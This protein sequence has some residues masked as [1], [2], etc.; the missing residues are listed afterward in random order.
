M[1]R[2][3]GALGRGPAH[4][5]GST[6]ASWVGRSLH[7]HQWRQ[8]RHGCA[9]S[10]PE[11]AGVMCNCSCFDSSQ[12]PSAQSRGCRWGGGRN[13]ATLK[14]GLVC[15]LY[16]LGVPEL[17][18]NFLINIILVARGHMCI[19]FV[20]S[21]EVKHKRPMK[22]EQ[23][24]PSGGCKAGQSATATQI[25]AS[26]LAEQVYS[27]YAGQTNKFR[28]PTRTWQPGNRA[29]HPLE[30]GLRGEWVDGRF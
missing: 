12:R 26:A 1:G 17:N 6:I 3:F 21:S 14:P 15:N 19:F 5:A 27:Q 11:L 20:C 23:R 10:R 24:K 30:S 25:P 29:A 16:C 4:A 22:S 7:A 8:G 18:A 13:G 2:G 28:H 9:A